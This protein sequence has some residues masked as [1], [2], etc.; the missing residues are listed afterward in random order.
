MAARTKRAP[1]RKRAAKKAPARKKPDGAP[2]APIE[3]SLTGELRYKL[4]AAFLEWQTEEARILVAAQ[5]EIQ[6][7]LDRVRRNDAAWRRT[8]KARLAAF[9]EVVDTMTPKLPEGFAIKNIDASEGTYRAEHDP[10]N[11]GQ[12]VS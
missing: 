12:H 9:N 8:N 7:L 4:K 1:A 3:K 2:S 10:E 11:R 6:K 5:K